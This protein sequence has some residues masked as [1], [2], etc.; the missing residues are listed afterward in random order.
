MARAPVP[1]PGGGADGRIPSARERGG[2][3]RGRDNTWCE[4]LRMEV[5][6]MT[7]SIAS[8]KKSGGRSAPG[9]EELTRRIRE[10]AFELFQKRG[11]AHGSDQ[12]DW[13]E[14]ER[15]VLQQRGRTT[16]ARREVGR[17]ADT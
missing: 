3:S 9:G 12:A 2:P 1:F 11:Y 8:S 10:K 13:F 4:S 15:I 17:R 5:G 16:R 7:G 14:A 6:K